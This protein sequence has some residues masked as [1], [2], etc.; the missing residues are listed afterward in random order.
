MTR[1]KKMSMAIAGIAALV[2]AA[3]T[4]QAV[5]IT[6]GGSALLS[7]SGIDFFSSATEIA[8]KTV[9]FSAATFQGTLESEVYQ[10]S[11]GTLDFVYLVT[12]DTCANCT[13]AV[14]RVSVSKFTGVTA[15]VGFTT[16]PGDEVFTGAASDAPV[17]ADRSG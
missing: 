5:T 9:S 8:E 7:D 10:E 4:A 15:D 14:E 6:P 16:N 11:G 12:L 1:L 17:S 13:D 2:V 3:G